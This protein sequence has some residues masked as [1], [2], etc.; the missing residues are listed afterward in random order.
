MGRKYKDLIQFE[1]IETVVQ[2]RSADKISEARR[3]VSTYVISE[4]M[5]ERLSEIVI[6]GL[7]FLK[8]SDNKGIL[9]VGN[10]GTGKSHLM[11]V[12]SAI[13]EHEEL[14]SELQNPKVARA[15]KVIAG[16]F[17]VIRTEL[18][19]TTM[20]LRDILVK[21]M[22]EA[23]ASM[24]VAYRFPPLDQIS[25][26]KRVF[27]EMMAA[28]HKKYP[29]QGLLLVVDELLDYLRSRKD[30][31]LILDLN[32]LREIGEVCKDLRFRFL[33]GVQEAIFDSP[34][35]HFVADSLRRVKDRFEQVLIA[36][37]DIK[38]VVAERLLRKNVRQQ[39]QIRAYLTPFAKFYTSMNERMD[40]FVRL[41]PVHPDYIDVFER[42]TVVEKRE[43]LKTLS[44]A[45]RKLLEQELPSDYPGLVSYDSYWEILRSEPSFR[46]IPEV[47]AVIDCS[48]V[49]ESRIQQ[50]FTP[51]E[52][53]P[54]A[55]RII[56]ALS[57]HRLTTGDIYTPI[58]P[59]V[60]ELCDTLCLYQPGVEDL[61][62][63]PA[64]DLVTLVE[65][66]LRTI[67][68]T[69]S[70]QFLSY[71]RDNGQWYLDLKKTEDYDALIEK[72]SESLEPSQLDRYY[73]EALK[74]VMECT[75]QTY[76]TGFR[77]WEYEL[78]W[79]SRRAARQG[80]LFFG[81]PNER[82][83]AV[84]PRDFYLYFLQPFDPPRFQ[85]EK[86]KDEVLF[87]LKHRDEEF[88]QKLRF[89]AAALELAS[90]ASGHARKVYTSKADDYL[91]DIVE[92]LQKHM[93][94]AFEVTWRGQ[95]KSLL[96]W[97]RS[98]KVGR[99]TP[100]RYQAGAVNIRDLVNAVSG[101]LLSEHFEDQAR[102]YPYFSL[103]I[104]TRSRPQAAQDAL[105]AIAGQNRT[106][107]AIAV[108]DALELL[109]GDRLDPYRSPYARYVLEMLREKGHGQVI[110]R[111]ELFKEVAKGVEYFG[112]SQGFRLEPEWAMVVLASLVYSGDLVLAIPGEKFDATSLEQL[113]A[114]SV[115]QLVNFKHVERP[116][117][118][119]VPALKK[120]FELLGLAPGMA[121]LITQ[122]KSEPVQ[123]L[124][125][126]VAQT[127]ERLVVAQ[128]RLQQGI[129]LWGKSLLGEEEVAQLQQQLRNA[130][131]FFE[132]LEVYTSPGKLKNF[133][134]D[135]D[136]VQRQKRGLEALAQ[137]EMFEEFARHLTPSVSYLSQAMM[138][139]PEDHPWVEK[140]R[141]LQGEM[142][143]ELARRHG[144]LIHLG[145]QMEGKLTELKKEYQR[146][147]GELH[148]RA[149]LS[150]EEERRK[151]KLLHS[152]ERLRTLQALA[153]IPIMPRQQLLEFQNRLEKLKSCSCLTEQDLEASPVCPHC[154]FQPRIEGERPP[155]K[156]EL[157]YL[158]Q[159]LD[160]MLE[161][162]TKV[163]LENLEDPTS[164]S[165]LKLLKPHDRQRVEEFLQSKTLPEKISRD[166]LHA[167]QEVLSDLVK[168]TIR[169]EE[170][171]KALQE[172][173]SPAT[174]EELKNRFEEFL[175]RRIR[176]HE[177]SKVR[178]L[179]EE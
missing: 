170:L 138:V 52:E 109:D 72:R 157:N 18:G 97:A 104:T 74:R 149:R 28:F 156:E 81:S 111:A 133:P 79:P 158:D 118:W 71:N 162:W 26:H 69:V 124:Q 21:D 34:R 173:G 35:F 132:S 93:V 143:K 96:E 110:N 174:L 136:Q 107:Q 25:S 40:E 167:L 106:K 47:K 88:D 58:G 16:K 50:A 160:A 12:I 151:E 17:R 101:A 163:L 117:E 46:A 86:K 142:E 164:Q 112:V 24:G 175:A 134:Y 68:K 115:Q 148:T 73:Y 144:S 8:P 123:E 130:K 82:S 62:G 121:E 94:E 114:T 5:A 169:R 43:V 165:H 155:A 13:C 99:F 78:E 57:V 126:K 66:V 108:L 129:T 11:S 80:Y 2:L 116:R 1:P 45:M 161:N 9:I 27:E 87:R 153:N 84:P 125:R 120:L 14:L 7:Q 113:A 61:G 152:D 89:Y 38:F 42:I 176:G 100:S 70:G 15:A 145:I 105:K 141:E 22:E 95:R 135:L 150:V 92:W 60:R 103:F 147:Y 154:H 29:D 44:G 55:R 56:H 63:D 64:E 127:L 76:V 98:K 67:Q 3:L 122:G 172:G 85:D 39:T 178:I 171:W 177:P 6:P 59:T 31:E 91:K 10:Y 30:Q 119:N 36:R 179:L 41:F 166:F 4:E 128:Q 146:L 90:T 48:Q 140:A 51:E 159:Q 37:N 33:A 139:L 23:L 54:L 65:S 53:K 49:L 32:F 131:E 102:R 75:D 168:V 19:S 83:T 137:V 20:A 77:I